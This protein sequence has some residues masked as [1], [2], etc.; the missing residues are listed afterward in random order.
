MSDKNQMAG[1]YFAELAGIIDVLRSPRGCPWDRART[2]EEIVNYFLEEVYEAVEAIEEGRPASVREEL[3]D[4]LMEIVFLTQFYE[5]AGKFHLADVVK[6]INRKMKDRHPHVFGGKNRQELTA[7][8]VR[9]N[10]MEKK[11]KEKKRSS[12]LEGLPK[13]APALLYAF[14]LGQRAAT[15]GFDWPDAEAALSKVKEE[16]TELEMS[17][18]QKRRSGVAEELGDLFFSLAMVSRLLGYNPEI[19]LR[20]ANRKFENRFKKMEIKLT[21]AGRRIQ[22]CTLEELDR[23]WEDVKK[24]DKLKGKKRKKTKNRKR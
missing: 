2:R 21:S 17:L 20:R 12:V 10:W 5:E 1:N 16:I 8:A 13:N 18:K 14:F 24:E 22:D 15:S 6:G 23:V 11:M 3:G 7:E 9:E 4:V 19:I